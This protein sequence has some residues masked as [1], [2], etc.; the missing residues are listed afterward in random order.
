M[1][2]SRDLKY[3]TWGTQ[4]CQIVTGRG[5]CPNFSTWCVGMRPFWK[6]EQIQCLLGHEQTCGRMWE[7]STNSY[8]LLMDL[9]QI[10]YHILSKSILWRSW[11]FQIS[12]LTKQHFS[13]H[14]S[15]IVLDWSAAPHQCCHCWCVYRRLGKMCFDYKKKAAESCVFFRIKAWLELQREHV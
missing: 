12:I 15:V 5:F 13:D 11:M 10:H 2:K 14:Q 6:R 7:T 1:W 8:L 9:C 4:G 3:S